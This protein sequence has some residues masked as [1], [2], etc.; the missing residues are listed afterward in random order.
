MANVLHFAVNDAPNAACGAAIF[1]CD[2][3]TDNRE[4]VDC[5][6]CRRTKQFVNYDPTRFDVDVWNHEGDVI[7]WFRRVNAAEVESIRQQYADN[8]TATISVVEC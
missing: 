1:L 8:P 7:R 5:K 6:R 3:Y 4:Y 2:D